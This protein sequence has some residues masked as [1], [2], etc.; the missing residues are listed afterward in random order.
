MAISEAYTGTASIST[1]EYSLTNNS[2]SIATQTTDGIYQ[3]FLD[4][5]AMVAG[6]EYEIRILEKCRTGDT[7]REV[8]KSTLGGDQGS[9]L[10]VTPALVLVNGWDMTVKRTAGAD[11]TI[12]WSIRSVA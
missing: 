6:D 12:L 8:Y 1:T 7:Q 4:V 2:T 3:L 5:D 10:F 9:A 11:R